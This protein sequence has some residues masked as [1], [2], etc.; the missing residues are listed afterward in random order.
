MHATGRRRI[1]SYCAVLAGILLALAV[2]GCGSVQ[3]QVIT[4]ANLSGEDIAQT[5][6]AQI[7]AALGQ[8]SVLEKLV[9]AQPQSPEALLALALAY[10]RDG[11]SARAAETLNRA[12]ALAPARV[13]LLRARAEVY[14]ALGKY[15]EAIADLTAALEQE[16][17]NADVLRR[18]GDFLQQSG[19][20]GAALDDYRAYLALADPQ[21]ANAEL[22]AWFEAVSAALGDADAGN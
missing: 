1:G 13:D 11:D 14:A 5:V 9:E 3:V 19:Q 17:Q 16:P 21:G 4:G 22:Q 2:A 8:T 10:Q 12:L 6:G 15:H 20:P 18:R 7:E